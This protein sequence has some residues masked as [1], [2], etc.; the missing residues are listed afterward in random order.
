MTHDSA[1]PFL[2]F[3]ILLPAGAAV[4]A[5]CVPASIGERRQRLVVEGVGLVATVATLALA[6]T[7]AVTYQAASSSN[8]QATKERGSR[9]TRP[10]NSTSGNSTDVMSRRKTEMPSTPRCQPMPSDGAHW[11]SLTSR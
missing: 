6:V 4:V 10:A 11:W 1:F 7:I 5:A 8:S 3:L 9:R 2:T